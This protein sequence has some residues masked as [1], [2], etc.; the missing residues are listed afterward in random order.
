VR[1]TSLIRQA[2]LRATGADIHEVR[3]LIA[4]YEEAC[5]L[6]T[7]TEAFEELVS[8]HGECRKKLGKWALKW[9]AKNEAALQAYVA[10]TPIWSVV[11]APH[12]PWWYQF[13][14]RGLLR[15]AGAP[16]RCAGGLR[17]VA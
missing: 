3:N 12:G 8:T 2:S 15:S 13:K 11:S 17:H 4:A 14:I 1:D 9:R 5:H 7:N 6:V 10:G 16:F